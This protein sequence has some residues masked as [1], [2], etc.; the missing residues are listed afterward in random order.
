MKITVTSGS[1]EGETPLAAFD[2]AL[3]DAGV[4]NY[5]LIKLSSVIPPNSELVLEK[6]RADK[7]EFGDRLYVVCAE[8]R[9]D[10]IGRS[11]AAGI[12]WYQWE[13]GRGVFAE[14]H[15]I[16]DSLDNKEAEVNVASKLEKTVKNLC[17][18]RGI[19]FDKKKLGMQ[20]STK[21]VS[22]KPSCTL[23]IAVYKSSPW[24]D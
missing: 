9:T 1:G 4:Y 20:I 13:D 10:L 8:E 22:D 6:F 3:K 2:N 11:I 14:Q 18:F 12:G 21:T 15:D 5:N 23:V 24:T 19:K 16:V 7:K 17:E